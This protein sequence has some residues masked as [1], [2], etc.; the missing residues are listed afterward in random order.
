MRKSFY[1]PKGSF[2]KK[3]VLSVSR[4][5]PKETPCFEIHR[6]EVAGAR[7][8]FAWLNLEA[9]RFAHQC[10]GIVGLDKLLSALNL[11]L[12]NEGYVTTRLVFPEQNLK[13]GILVLHLH[14]GR[15]GEIRMVK[16]LKK[17]KGPGL[18]DLPDPKLLTRIK[19]RGWGTWRN[20]FPI[21]KGEVLNVRHMEQGVERMKR[22]QSQKIE[23]QIEPG[24]RADTSIIYIER[25]PIRFIDRF[26]GGLTLDNS[27]S[28]SLSHEQFSGYFSYEN[29]LG[30]NDLLNFNWSS[31]AR[32]PGPDHRGQSAAVNYAIPLGY[33]LL[34]LSR[35]YSRF[36]QVIQGH[37]EPLLSSGQSNTSDVRLNQTLFR[38][39]QGMF[40]GYVG[41]SR[42][43]ANSFLNGEEIEVQ[44]RKVTNAELGLTGQHLIGERASLGLDG[45]IRHG[46]KWGGVQ[47]DF[48][49]ID[50]TGEGLFFEK[51]LTARPTIV[52]Y[53]ANYDQ[54]I[55]IGKRALQYAFYL[56]G[57]HTKNTTLSVDQ[58]AIGSRYT[59]RGF[60]GDAV[61]M[62]ENGYFIRNDLSIPIKSLLK[63]GQTY[64]YW[65][66]DYGHVWGP[67]SE[68]QVGTKLS[69]TVVGIRGKWQ[70]FWLDVA[71]GTPL[72]KP[73][74]FTTRRINPYLT[75]SYQ[76]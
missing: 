41:A 56:H 57:Q 35:S 43:Q 22:L 50:L 12:V 75:L 4:R 10:I 31:N 38:T 3:P 55:P 14:V 44:R 61:L 58:I 23:T 32:N 20:A 69:G 65:G 68:G 30:L 2:Q 67:S 45:G 24:S 59:V 1:S 70:G 48:L 26:H 27:G 13:S 42:N 25:E 36:A 29:P 47:E 34:T 19:D 74:G 76:F 46:V 51:G 53:N 71:V 33:S 8:R 63:G 21:K 62:S 5:L 66:I 16:K 9:N 49:P 7:G 6:I 73:K 54:V 17:P 64:L 72:Y 40:G 15:I 60:D 18:L 28:S 11:R 52:T 37:T 39:S